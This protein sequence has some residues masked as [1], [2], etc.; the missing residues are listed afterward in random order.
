MFINHG[1]FYTTLGLSLG[2]FGP[3][4]S[5][6]LNTPMD[7]WRLKAQLKI[8][9]TFMSCMGVVVVVVGEVWDGGGWGGEGGGG[10][11]SALASLKRHYPSDQRH[12]MYTSVLSSFKTS[13]RRLQWKPENVLH[14]LGFFPTW[15]RR[16]SGLQSL[17][18]VEWGLFVPPPAPRPSPSVTLTHTHTHT[19]RKKQKKI[20]GEVKHLKHSRWVLEICFCFLTLSRRFATQGHAFLPCPLTVTHVGNAHDR[21]LCTPSP[22]SRWLLVLRLRDYN[23]RTC[24]TCCVSAEDEMGS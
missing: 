23:L 19:H 3:K 22:T 6:W 8:S 20:A 5:S 15:Q 24:W 11:V 18:P 14:V 9:P 1:R 13:G 17:P 21:G 16:V 4:V 12:I 7:A 2:D 10:P